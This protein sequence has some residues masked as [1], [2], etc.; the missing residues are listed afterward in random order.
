MLLVSNKLVGALLLIGMIILFVGSWVLNHRT[1]IPEGCKANK[2][3]CTGCSIL[4]CP[5]RKSENVEEPK[6][7]IVKTI[8]MDREAK[9]ELEK[10]IKK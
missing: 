9:E 1:K 3:E 6:E 5:S 10:N 4:T 8:D 2:P 7:E